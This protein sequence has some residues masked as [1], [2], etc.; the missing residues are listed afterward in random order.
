[1]RTEPNW[2]AVIAVTLTLTVG[3]GFVVWGILRDA[4]AA[5]HL[6]YG[7]AAMAAFIVFLNVYLLWVPIR[8]CLTSFS[9][10]GVTRLGVRGRR[11]YSW[12]QLIE[13]RSRGNL[14]DFNFATGRFRFNLLLFRN[15]AAIVQFVRSHVRPDQINARFST[16]DV[17]W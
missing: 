11:L 17:L 13:I 10:E 14:A 4:A 5:N 9:D 2:I 1:M 6:A 3:C 15:S 12:S 16:G 7:A 8:D